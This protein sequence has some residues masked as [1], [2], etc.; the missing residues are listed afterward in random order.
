MPRRR[1]YYPLCA[2]PSL[3]NIR[4]HLCPIAAPP[5]ESVSRWSCPCHLCSYR[6]EQTW[7]FSAIV[8]VVLRT[9]RGGRFLKRVCVVVVVWVKKYIL[10]L[11]ANRVILFCLLYDNMSLFWGSSRQDLEI[12]LHDIKSAK[13]NW[14]LDGVAH[15]SIRSSNPT[16]TYFCTFFQDLQNHSHL[17][18]PH[19]EILFKSPCVHFSAIKTETFNPAWIGIYLG[20]MPTHGRAAWEMGINCW[21]SSNSGR[22]IIMRK[23]KRKWI[24]ICGTRFNCLTGEVAYRCGPLNTTVAPR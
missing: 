20:G 19:T 21:I 24:G 18:Q 6:R 5:S 22:R 16:G 9:R 4:K 12:S 13:L 17:W 1:C 23:D 10:S 8:V 2:P 3:W 11:S 15:R 7:C 14:D